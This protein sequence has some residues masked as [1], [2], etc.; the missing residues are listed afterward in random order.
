LATLD[1]SLRDMQ[2]QL[3]LSVDLGMQEIQATAQALRASSDT[4][5]TTSQEFSDPVR[6]LYGP[7]K[8]ELGPGEE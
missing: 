3:R 1:A 5:Q 7:N 2:T 4:L 6:L 8:A